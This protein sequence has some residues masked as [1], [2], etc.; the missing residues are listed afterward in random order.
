M[1]RC[2]LLIAINHELSV[3]EV[4]FTPSPLNHLWI[5]Q[6]DFFSL[7]DTQLLPVLSEKQ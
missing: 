3:G 4:I 1:V 2:S 6:S 5:V 7:F